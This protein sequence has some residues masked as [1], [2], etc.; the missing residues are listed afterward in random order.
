MAKTT[1]SSAA[2]PRAS[3]KGNLAFGL[4]TF[5]VQAFNALDRHHGDI[6]FHQL[7]AECHRRIHYQKVCPVHGEVT[8]DE[9]VSGYEYKKGHYVEIDPEEL[10]AL[11]TQAQRALTIDA[12][13]DPGGVDPLY[14]DGRMYYLL[15]DG[16]ASAEPYAVLAAAMDREERVG[17]G[18]VVFSGKDQLVLVRPLDGVLHMAMLNYESEIRPPGEII[19]I[20]RPRGVGR[21]IKL[22]QTLIRHWKVD[23]FDFSRYEDRYREE[24]QELITAKIEGREIVEPEVEEVPEVVNLIDAL[25]KSLARGPGAAGRKRRPTRKR[26]SA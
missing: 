5:P 12:F 24:L 6:H 16:E 19:P 15:P 18:R 10:D 9:I 20:P 25:K 23:D 22:A 4:V 8:N 13:I 3:W 17:I 7:H 14:F 26:R 21:Q 1:R 2:N 11:R